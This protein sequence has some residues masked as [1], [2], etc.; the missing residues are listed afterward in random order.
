MSGGTICYSFLF[1]LLF[2]FLIESKAILYFR[3][4]HFI[5]FI[6]VLADSEAIV[7]KLNPLTISHIARISSFDITG[8]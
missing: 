4:A 6:S 3:S 2:T 5:Y 8:R 7:D 1:Y